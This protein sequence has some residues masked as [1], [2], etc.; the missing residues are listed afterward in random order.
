MVNGAFIERNAGKGSSFFS[1]NLRMS[2]A[3]PLGSRLRLEALIEGFNVTN[4]RNVVARNANF[5]VGAYPANPSPG[6]G[7]VLAVGEPRSAQFGLRVR[8]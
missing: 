7:R 8:F 2:R 3:F 6:F 5:G 4:R 1:L